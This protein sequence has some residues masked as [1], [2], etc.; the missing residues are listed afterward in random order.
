MKLIGYCRV[1]SQSQSE[2]TSLEGQYADL[3]RYCEQNGHELVKVFTEVGS[4]KSVETRPKFLEA[5]EAVNGADGLV[6]GKLDRFGRHCRGFLGIVEDFFVPTGKKLILLDLLGL[7]VT[8]PSGKFEATIFAGFSELERAKILER[9]KQ[10]IVL[11]MGKGVT[12]GSPKYGEK[13]Q[14]KG[15]VEVEEELKV[16]EFIRRQ[17]RQ[18]VSLNGI[19]KKLNN[20]ENDDNTKGIPTKRGKKWTAQGVKNVLARF[21]HYKKAS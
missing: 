3:V 19:A 18:G 15:R 11:A 9:I 17:Y 8:T 13:A 21:K 14:S 7:D 2:N 20:K 16:I 4:G 6:V 10:G 5:M 1:S 12:F